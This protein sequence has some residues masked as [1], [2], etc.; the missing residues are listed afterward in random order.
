M[1]E[2]APPRQGGG[3]DWVAHAVLLAGV[4]LFALPIW[5]VLVGSTHDAATIGRGEVPLLPGRFAVENYAAAWN[6]G[7]AGARGG[8]KAICRRFGVTGRCTPTIAPI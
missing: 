2:V 6:R 3:T 4:A 1:A 8:V 5:V 7:G